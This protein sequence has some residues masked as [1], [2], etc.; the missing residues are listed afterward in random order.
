M[1]SDHENQSEFGAAQNLDETRD[2][3]SSFSPHTPSGDPGKASSPLQG[4]HSSK[5]GTIESPFFEN[6]LIGR[7][8]VIREIGKGGFGF[9]YLARDPTL[10]RKVAIKYPRLHRA[11]VRKEVFLEEG[12]AVAKLNHESIVKIYNIE[13][14]EQGDPYVVMEYVK[15]PTLRSIIAEEGLTLTTSLQYLI[16]IGEA[17]SYAHS[18][19]LIHRD[20]K[21]ANVI[22]T[23]GGKMVKLMDFG[24]ALH[25]MTP[26][27]RL[28][29]TPEGTPPY[30]S[31]EQIRCE[32]H[33]LDGRTDI[34]AFGVIM[35]LMLT[36]R[37]PFLRKRMSELAEEICL[38]DPKLPRAINASIPPELERIC[39][40]CLE[41]LMSSRYQSAKELLEDLKGFQE[42][43]VRELTGDPTMDSVVFSPGA[44]SGEGRSKSGLSQSGSQTRKSLT[45]TRYA[46]THS[47]RVVPKGLRSFDEQDAE[48]FVDLL[49][50]PKDRHNVPES[51]RFWTNKIR[52]GADE[53][54]SVGLI[55]G[56]SGC[57]KSSFVKAGLIP[58]LEG[59]RIAYIEASP[60]DTENRILQ[61]LARIAPHAANEHDDLPRVFARIRRGQLL[62]GEKTLIVIDQF[63]QWLHSHPDLANQLLVDALRHCDGNSL[64]LPDAG[65]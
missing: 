47:V 48:F 43:W 5:S 50:G 51:L 58:H 3:N 54:V 10:D 21:P 4:S 7:Y 35:Y 24:L 61:K 27:D 16:Q 28:P 55:Y 29:T 12:R 64:S 20:L 33:R 31:P 40:K 60:S 14:T 36:G 42:Q 57:G 37:R 39:L 23:G 13:E 2:Q 19:T 11:R 52:R 65:S 53:P 49:P 22:I 18:K 9:V 17:L 56:P 25:D 62:T 32:N 1:D 59:I 26:E 15:G 46:E 30:M 45:E 41:K 8:V 38:H 44:I 6:D 34:W 63:E